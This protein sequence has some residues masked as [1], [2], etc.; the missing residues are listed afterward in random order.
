[1]NELDSAIINYD[2]TINLDNNSAMAFNNRGTAFLKKGDKF[3][4]LLSY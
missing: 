3:N 1:M 4:A 2:K